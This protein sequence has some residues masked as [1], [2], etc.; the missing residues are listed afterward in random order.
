MMSQKEVM[1]IVDSA[2]A[3]PRPYM[4]A[5][6]LPGND[7]FRLRLL[8]EGKVE[9]MHISDYAVDKHSAMDGV[10]Q[11][12]DDLPEWMQERLAVLMVMRHEPPTTEVEGVGRRISRDVFWVL[13]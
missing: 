9:V 3:G 1:R 4:V 2:V 12:T 10:Y 6:L 7:V 13:R 8:C 11:S 5:M